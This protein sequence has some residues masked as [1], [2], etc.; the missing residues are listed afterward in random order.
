MR[1]LNPIGYSLYYLGGSGNFGSHTPLC[2]ISF[3]FV[4]LLFSHL[5]NPTSAC[6]KFTPKLHL[7]NQLQNNKNGKEDFAI[8]FCSMDRSEEEYKAYSEQMPWWCLP[9][10]ISTLPKLAQIYHAHGIPHLVILD[11]NGKVITKEGV[12]A[13]Q[14]DPVGRLF[15]WRPLRVVDLLPELYLDTDNESY[16][17]TEE[18]EEKYLMLYFSEH[19]CG[20]CQDFTPWLVKAYNI[21]KQRRPDD[22]EVS[23]CTRQG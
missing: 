4:S 6:N 13:L 14:Q 15:P 16:L 21:L 5:Y 17:E 9:Y 22:F 2:F 12:P 23:Y 11:T 10:A 18:L 3:H 19:G 8:V 7:F 20:L 1:D